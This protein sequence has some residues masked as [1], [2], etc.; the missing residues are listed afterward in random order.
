MNIYYYKIHTPYTLKH[1]KHKYKTVKIV[2]CIASEKG[3]Q[4]QNPEYC[5]S[6][7]FDFAFRFALENIITDTMRVSRQIIF[8]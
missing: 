4:S 8:K 6:T 7:L 1:L 5:V 2:I 3:Y